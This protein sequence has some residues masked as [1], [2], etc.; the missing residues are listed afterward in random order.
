MTVD[1]GD[2]RFWVSKLYVKFDNLSANGT[3]SQLGVL[4]GPHL[5]DSDILDLTGTFTLNDN[6]MIYQLQ[7][8]V[9]VV[10]SFLLRVHC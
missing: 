10:F 6:R 5:F 4:G 2:T 3:L 8:V 1:K 7:C 9:D